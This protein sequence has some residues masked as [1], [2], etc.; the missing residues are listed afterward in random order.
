MNNIEEAVVLMLCKGNMRL[1]DLQKLGVS[2]ERLRKVLRRNGYDFDKNG[3]H[4]DDSPLNPSN[5]WL[6]LRKENGERL[7][8]FDTPCLNDLDLSIEDEEANEDKDDCD[9]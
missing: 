9:C 3:P 6:D 7:G 2:E 8:L 5:T 1:D 4:F